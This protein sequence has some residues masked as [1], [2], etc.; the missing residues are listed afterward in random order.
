M[1]STKETS[2]YISL[3]LRHKPE[4]IGITLD[5]H[6]WARVDELIEGV[7][8]THPLNMFKGCVLLTPSINSS[9]L[10]HPCSSRVIPIT[11]GLCL[12]IK[13]M[14]LLVSFVLFIISTDFCLSLLSHIFMSD[15]IFYNKPS[16]KG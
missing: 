6:G 1:K 16:Q 12:K 5:E 11:S 3:I 13:L 4:V 9:T 2:K 15:V 8:R 14:Y 10:A 7:S